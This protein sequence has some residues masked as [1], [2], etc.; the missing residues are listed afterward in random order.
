MISKNVNDGVP[1][2]RRNCIT[3]SKITR[4][5]VCCRNELLFFLLKQAFKNTRTNA[6][7]FAQ[8]AAGVLFDCVPDR[9]ECRRLHDHKQTNKKYHDALFETPKPEKIHFPVLGFGAFTPG[10]FRLNVKGSVAASFAE[11]LIFCGAG[12]VDA[13]VPGY[14]I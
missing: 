12:L 7:F 3:E 13:V 1:I 5:Y 2:P 10:G 6:K 8:I 14:H 4:Q 9:E 11:I